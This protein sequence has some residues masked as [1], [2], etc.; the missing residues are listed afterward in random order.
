MEQ[1]T[2]AE[3]QG[4]VEI[5][6]SLLGHLWATIA[7]WIT[8]DLVVAVLATALAM[9][10]TIAATHYVKLVAPAFAPAVT[11]E[12]PTWVAFCSTASVVVGAIAG[13]LAWA[14]SPATWVAV[15]VA[16][17]GSGP[18]WIVLRSAIRRRWPHLADRF[19]TDT[20]RA[21]GL[22]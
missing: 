6:R 16:A 7:P 14:S 15:P 8:I 4:V 10:C 19:R 12:R 18:A 9:I 11:R 1:Q 13:T 22:K 17:V 2:T 20:D 5:G 3:P 21:V